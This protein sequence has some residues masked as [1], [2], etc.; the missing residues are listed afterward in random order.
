AEAYYYFGIARRYLNESRRSDSEPVKQLSA[1]TEYKSLAKA[2][3]SRAVAPAAYLTLAEMDCCDENW[4]KALEHLDAS[5]RLD[6]DNLLARNLKAIVLR[7]L[8]RAN[9]AESLLRDT[10]ASDPLDAWAKYLLDRQTIADAQV[11]LD[12]AHDTARAGLFAEAI[13]VLRSG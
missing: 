10:L 2:A 12:I 3:W 11:R 1:S 5:L 8:S 13:D 6:I 4:N 7:K 9:E